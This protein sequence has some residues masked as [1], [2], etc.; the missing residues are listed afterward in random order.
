VE[1]SQQAHFSIGRD[2]DMCQEFISSIPKMQ[3]RR[4]QFGLVVS[5]ERFKLGLLCAVKANAS[6]YSVAGEKY[7]VGDGLFFTD[8]FNE[9]DKRKLNYYAS[10]NKGLSQWIASAPSVPREAWPR[11]LAAAQL[12]GPGTVYRIL[13]C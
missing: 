13:R 7:Q 4:L 11:A 2:Q 6:I 1:K 3:V 5:L 9:D 12:I 8:V 10:R